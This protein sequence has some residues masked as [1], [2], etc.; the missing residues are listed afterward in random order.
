[1][2]TLNTNSV[3]TEVPFM[4]HNVNRINSIQKKYK[5]LRQKSKAP[6]FALQ[7]A[8][9]WATIMKSAGVSEV[10]ARAIETNYHK[11]YQVSDAWIKDVLDTAHETGYIEGAFGLRIRTPLLKQT[12]LSTKM[13][14]MAQ[15]ERRSAG[16]AKTQSYG[17]LN[18]RAA[19]E[20]QRRIEA[21]GLREQV[22]FAALIHDAIYI[23][24][25]DTPRIV[26]WVNDNLIDC[27][28]WQELPELQ[29]DIVKMGAALDVYYPNWGTPLT[30][31]ND[32]SIQEIKIAAVDHLKKLK[33]VT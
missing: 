2:I 25:K 29:H 24:C 18:N 31:Q 3:I 9:T 4:E 17:L 26:R 5:A 22:L 14:H 27:M 6:T 16:N 28:R 20:F 32:L 10:E 8:G 33:E 12:I 30:L 23:V 11:L 19:I 7:Y 1:M 21:A 15:A 13:S